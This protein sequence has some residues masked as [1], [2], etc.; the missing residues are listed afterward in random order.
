MRKRLK[1]LTGMALNGKPNETVGPS[2]W[3]GR[4]R[5]PPPPAAPPPARPTRSPASAPASL[6]AA[7]RGMGPAAAAL[8]RFVVGTGHRHQQA[9]EARLG[10]GRGVEGGRGHA[11]LPRR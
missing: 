2:C 10:G 11:L 7:P 8:P 9:V 3:P 1:T 6:P 4:P 5:S